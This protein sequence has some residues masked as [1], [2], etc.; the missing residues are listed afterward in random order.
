[1]IQTFYK[2]KIEALFQEL[3]ND[4]KEEYLDD[5]VCDDHTR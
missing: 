1:M 4:Y 2:E 3:L 5:T